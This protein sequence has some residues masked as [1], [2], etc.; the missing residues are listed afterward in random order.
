[1]AQTTSPNTIV[2]VDD[3][4][5][6]VSWLQEY[7][8]GRGF[9]VLMAE[10]LNEALPL[11]EAEIHRA[12]IIDLNIPALSP[13]P[14]ILME[15]GGPYPSYPGLYLAYRARNLGY[16]D[17]QVLL[18]TVHR[19]AAVTQE[20]NLLGATYIIKGR[21]QEIKKEIDSVVAFDP[22]AP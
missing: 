10:T 11:V 15:R 17:R 14:A 3:E 6:N 4:W 19:E 2:L 7:L 13:L 16:R 1:M 8:E 22:T 12:L 18:Y 20:A 21:P 9:N 5:H